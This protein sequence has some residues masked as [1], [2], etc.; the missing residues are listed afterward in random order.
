MDIWRVV[1]PVKWSEEVFFSYCPILGSYMTA[2]PIA[3]QGEPG[4]NSDI[5]AR[6]VFPDRD[7]LPCLTFE[8]VFNAVDEHRA[9]YALIP[10]DNSIAGRVADIHLLLRHTSTYIIGEY[11]LPIQHSLLAL[12]G[13]TLDSI[14]EA[15]SHVHALAQC[16][17]FL[18]AHNITS[19]VTHDTAGAAR[20]V[21]EQDSLALA[22]IATPLAGKLYGLVEITPNIQ[23]TPTNTTR[24]LILSCKSYIPEL[25]SGS[26]QSFITSI[27]FSLPSEPASLYNAIGGFAANKINILKIESYLG[28]E[29]QTAEFYMEVEGHLE[30]EGT[31]KGIADLTKFS[32]TTRIL[33]T[34]E[35]SSFRTA[36]TKA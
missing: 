17:K 18:T 7:T 27:F 1:A 26:T 19:H 29:F 32:S 5:A 35:A 33:G 4:A 30:E 13:A 12:P 11:F 28:K 23:D 15:R 20:E 10:I 25:T 6:A 8:D 31:R 16:K 3:Y 2:R 21:S 24:F 14:R 34:Y 36:S 9:E 22:A